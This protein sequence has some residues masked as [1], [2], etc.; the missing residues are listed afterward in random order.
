MPAH[1]SNT[2]SIWIYL[3]NV[4][5]VTLTESPAPAQ[6]KLR[7][8]RFKPVLWAVMGAMTI[9]VMLYSEIPLLRQPQERTYL[10]TIPL[11]IVLHVIGGLSALLIGPLQFSQR[12]R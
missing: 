9:S 12:L 2:N 6:P 11:L 4:M 8:N 5:P 10:R 3:S 7:R 1:L